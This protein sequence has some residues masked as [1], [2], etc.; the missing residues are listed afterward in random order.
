MTLL[1][2]K[3][4]CYH[5]IEELGRGTFGKVLKARKKGTGQLVAIK[6]IKNDQK[7]SNVIKNEIKLL[8]VIRQVDLDASHLVCFY[9]H[10]R[11]QDTFCLVFE[12][13]HKNLYEYQKEIRFAPIPLRHIRTITA[14]VLEALSKLKELSIIHSDLKPENIV[15]VDQV[16]YPFRVKIIDFGSASILSDV[17]HVKEPYIQ[18]R[19]YRAPEILLGLPFCEKLD[20]WSLG[21]IIA[22]LH[23]G[24]PLFPGNSEYD[25]IKYICETQGLPDN[26]L[27]N[28]ASKA[29][30]FF[31]YTVDNQRKIR[32]R[33]KTEEYQ[34][35]PKVKPVERRKYILKSLDQIELLY[36]TNSYYP[37]LEVL[38]E[39]YD[40]RNMVEL[41]KRMLTWDS[42]KRINPN[43]ALRHPF[44]SLQH[45]KVHYRNSR[46]YQLSRQCQYDATDHLGLWSLNYYQGLINDITGGEVEKMTEQMNELH[47]EKAAEEAHLKMTDEAG[48]ADIQLC[49]LSCFAEPLPPDSRREIVAEQLD[50]YYTS[51][52]SKAPQYL[53]SAVCF[54]NLVFIGKQTPEPAITYDNINISI[55]NTLHL[56]PCNSN[57]EAHTTARKPEVS[58]T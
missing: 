27:L 18:S 4:D 45:L 7:R 13:L 41:M 33:M 44:I 46:Y 54:S 32:W 53:K 20:M 26:Y 19:F 25:Q 31:K 40:L 49:D 37:E 1:Q 36:E 29:L 50:N 47:I 56:S 48:H 23:F 52:T 8:N 3:T 28:A 35:A 57:V 22:E 51:T 5:V 21:C 34:L 58:T 14:Q 11:V 24:Y 12:L 38:A 55:A 9:E 15:L 30:F 43:T 6:V 10:F 2:S 17:K 16:R 42:N 39:R